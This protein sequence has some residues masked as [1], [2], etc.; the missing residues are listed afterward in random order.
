MAGLRPVR[1]EPVLIGDLPRPGKDAAAI[2]R[3]RRLLASMAPDV[4]HAHGMRAGAFAAVALRPWSRPP[5]PGFGQS[6]WRAA[7]SGRPP[8][9]VVTAHNA[10]PPGAAAGVA[11][12]LLERIVARRAD[13]VLCVSPDLSDRMIRLGAPEV[14]RAIVPA[15]APVSGPSAGSGQRPA[16][17]G[18]AG[19]PLVLAAAR[20]TAQK[21]L[22]TL[23][24]AAGRWRDRVPLPLVAIAGAGPLA[25]ALAARA[26]A[27]GADVTFLGWRDD[28]PALLAAADVFVLPSQWEGQ[29]LILQ[30]ALRAG[31]P[32]VAT[33]V[34]G[35][36]DLTGSDGAV[37]VPPGDPEALAAAVLS[38]LDSPAAAARLAAAAASRAAELPA[39]ADAIAAAL[40][41]YGRL[42]SLVLPPPLAHDL[43]DNSGI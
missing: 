14:S 9:L 36:R 39:E 13:L 34:G 22:G 2:R 10:P 31:R 20:L 4:V 40:R 1:F 29:P 17:L 38:V 11:F 7:G 28:V 19:R 42:A 24:E 26:R 12:W 16:S 25:G 32:I 6:A 37:L 43:D 3:L 5:Q 41:L 8:A 27:D 21:G 18:A 23:V 33:D 35:V 30:E 15:P